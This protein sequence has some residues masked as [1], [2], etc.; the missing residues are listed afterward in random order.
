[1]GIVTSNTSCLVTDI[2]RDEVKMK[3]LLICL[4]R[5]L[6][7]LVRGNRYLCRGSVENVLSITITG[8]VTMFRW[9]VL[10]VTVVFFG[11]FHDSLNSVTFI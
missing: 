3:F 5:Y 10:V 6:F 4:D 7:S 11:F 9:V 8:N 2:F 1:M